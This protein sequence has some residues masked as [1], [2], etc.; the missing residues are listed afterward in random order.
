MNPCTNH[1]RRDCP[2]LACKRE[3]DRRTEATQ[4]DPLT[5]PTSP[6]HQAVH[7][8]MHY[9]AADTG[10]SPS[11][12]GDC[13]SSSSSGSYDSGSSSSSSCDSGGGGW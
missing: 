12:S 2:D 11:P 1:R 3:R 8:G 6:I 13:G 10:T 4:P 5:D 9:G 7:G